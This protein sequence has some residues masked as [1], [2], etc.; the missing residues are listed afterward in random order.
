MAYMVQNKYYKPKVKEP[1]S[2]LEYIVS[3]GIQKKI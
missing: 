3:T 1:L 2:L